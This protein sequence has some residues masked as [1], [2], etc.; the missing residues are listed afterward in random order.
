[1][2]FEIKDYHVIQK[3]KNQNIDPKDNNEIKRQSITLLMS[4]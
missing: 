3:K 2:N 1:M 4:F